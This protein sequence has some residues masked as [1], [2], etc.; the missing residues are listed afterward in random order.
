MSIHDRSREWYLG[1]VKCYYDLKGQN[2]PLFAWSKQD[3][4]NKYVKIQE[5]LKGAVV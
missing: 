2:K 1:Y 3:L 4:F 5:E